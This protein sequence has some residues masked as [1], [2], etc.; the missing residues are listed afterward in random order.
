MARELKSKEELSPLEDE[1]LMPFG[2]Y[3][4]DKMQDVPAK[5]LL[6]INDMIGTNAR[7]KQYI[8]A[9][10]EIIKLQAKNE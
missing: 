10:L 6:Y 7:V 5:Y 1:D 8:Q 2:K 9:N 3:K 4:G